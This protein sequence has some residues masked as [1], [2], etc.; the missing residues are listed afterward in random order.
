MKYYTPEL[1]DRFASKDEQTALAAQ[2]ELEDRSEEYDKHLKSIAKKLPPRFCEL[3]ERFY[4]HNARVLWPFLPWHPCQMP[5]SNAEIF[6]EMTAKM[7][8]FDRSMPA[9]LM[10]PVELDAPPRDL[11]VLHYRGVDPDKLNFELWRDSR[12]PTLRWLHD[13]VDVVPV[14]GGIEFLHG[15]LF[16]EGIELQLQF[17]DFD[18]A[19]LKPMASASS[20]PSPRAKAV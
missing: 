2:D 15:I 1:L 8:R 14:N 16:S 5:P 17:A 19:V 4:L 9:S 10:L 11:I 20:P 7:R 13:E 3:Q 18:F 12:L 6:R